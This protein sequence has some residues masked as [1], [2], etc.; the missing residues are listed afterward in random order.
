MIDFKTI[1][2]GQK[3]KVQLNPAHH[4]LDAVACVKHPELER[5]LKQPFVAHVENICEAGDGSPYTDIGL[6]IPGISEDDVYIAI[7]DEWDAHRFYGVILE[8][9]NE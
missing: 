9:I 5:M 8:V 3:V 2:A 4:W 1:K 7:T 6:T